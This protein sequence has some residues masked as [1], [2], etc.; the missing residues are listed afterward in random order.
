LCSP[1]ADFGWVERYAD[2]RK[3]LVKDGRGDV[4]NV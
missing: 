4:K 1:V 3:V 2:R